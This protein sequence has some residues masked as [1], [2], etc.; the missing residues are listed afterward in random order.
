MKKSTESNSKKRIEVVGAGASGLFLAYALQDRGFDVHVYEKSYEVGGMARTLE[1]PFGKVETG[2]NAFL[3]SPELDRLAA[4]I[5]CELVP[6]LKSGKRRY[7]FRQGKARAVGPL[8]LGLFKLI[9]IVPLYLFKREKLR[10]KAGE[11]L[12]EWGYRILGKEKSEQILFPALQGI[13]AGDPA[14]LSAS[15]LLGRF[16]LDPKTGAAKPKPPLS[17]APRAGMGEFFYRLHSHL[18]QKGVTFHFGETATGAPKQDGV[19]RVYTGNPRT[20]S[21]HLKSVDVESSR[22]LSKVEV[23]PLQSMTL[24]FQNAPAGLKPGF[25]MLFP[26]SEGIRSLGVLFN[27]WV[28]PDRSSHH[29]ETWIL[30]GA[31]DRESISLGEE[32]CLELVLRDR[33]QAMG[34]REEPIFFHLTRWNQAIPHFNRELESLLHERTFSRQG[35]VRLFGTFQGVLGIGRIFERAIEFSHQL[36]HQQ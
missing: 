19:I 20:A 14:E 16:F 17:V 22:L 13:Y 9:Q 15:L 18:V 30:G 25:G 7:V 35:N 26:R 31:L 24:F 23:L 36:E 4:E 33:A 2:A 1:S 11:S 29:S 28:F 8:S 12:Q 27:S 6:R 34:I 10:P 3:Y 21:E 32:E 5:G